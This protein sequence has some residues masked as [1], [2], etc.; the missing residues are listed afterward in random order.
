M[1]DA[2][3]DDLAAQVGKLGTP[4]AELSSSGTHYALAVVGGIVSML[5]GTALLGLLG[6]GLLLIPAIKIK[7]AFLAFKLGAVA[8]V[9]LAAGW[10]VLSRG[11]A[12]RGLRVIVCADG[13]ARIHG[14]RAELLRWEDVNR[15]V[16]IVNA[17]KEGLT[18]TTP[19]QLTLVGREGQTMTFDEALAGLPELRR[20]A[21]EHTL[22]HMLPPALEALTAGETI[23]FGAVAVGPQG[24]Q[25]GANVLA[26]DRYGEAEAS[27]GQLIVRA[28]DGRR[29]FCKVEVSEV[30][31]VHVLL[32]LAEKARAG[33]AP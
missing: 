32:A 16:R 22:A 7:S 30:P 15:V 3:P 6:I 12:A 11:R 14:N 2:L 17:T 13:L 24:L 28:N 23:A 19:V 8:L 9:L 5:L 1:K 25:H 18:V 4:E 27:K 10:G 20:L 29:P 31:N 26:W 21:E 33:G